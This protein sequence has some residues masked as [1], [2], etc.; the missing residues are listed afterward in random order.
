MRQY[1]LKRSSIS[2]AQARQSVRNMKEDVPAAAWTLLRWCVAS[3]TAYIEELNS[4]PER[5]QNIG[6]FQT[7]HFKSH[8]PYPYLKQ[9]NGRVFSHLTF[10]SPFQRQPERIINSGSVW[11]LPK[12]RLN[13][14]QRNK[15]LWKR[16]R[17][18]RNIRRYM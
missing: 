4:A 11:V 8:V 3:C 12:P 15:L 13:L 9:T 6:M 14:K 1:L 16:T 10:T 18:L 17:M 2:T 5:V 7:S